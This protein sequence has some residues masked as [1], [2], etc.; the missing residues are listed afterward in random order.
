MVGE[1][2]VRSLL[3]RVVQ[4][5]AFLER[6]AV[7]D[8]DELRADEDAFGGVKYYFV[9]ALEGC[10]NVAQHLCAAE[11]WGPPA[12]NADAMLV[13]GRNGVLATPLAETMQDAVRF[14]NILVHEYAEIDDERVLAHLDDLGDIRAFVAAVSEWV[15]A[16]PEEYTPCP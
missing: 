3:N 11:G 15:D 16:H 2:R 6:R 1:R 14:R 10:I 4:N 13:L 8:R 9:I 7:R 12:T 5:L